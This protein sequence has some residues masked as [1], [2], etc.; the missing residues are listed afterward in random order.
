[1]NKLTLFG[2]ITDPKKFRKFTTKLEDKGLFATVVFNNFKGYDDNKKPINE[3]VYVKFSAYGNK[4]KLLTTL[5]KGARILVE[6]T[7]YNFNNIIENKKYQS[8]EYTCKSLTVIDWPMDVVGSKTFKVERED[9][10]SY[11]GETSLEEI[12]SVLPKEGWGQ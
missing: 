10:T 4:A 11:K 7:P 9:G 6:L 12:Q 5:E 2:R 1:M 3:P 8:L